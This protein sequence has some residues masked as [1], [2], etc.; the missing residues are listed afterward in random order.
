MFNPSASLIT[1]QNSVVMSEARQAHI[2]Q[3][4][5][6][7][8]AHNQI[9]SN[10]ILLPA[11]TGNS[12]SQYTN[13]GAVPN[14]PYLHGQTDVAMVNKTATEFGSHH[15]TVV[16]H[17]NIMATANME[18]V[19]QGDAM[20]DF[21]NI[22]PRL[23]HPFLDIDDL[24]DNNNLFLGDVDFSNTAMMH[25]HELGHPDVYTTPASANDSTTR[26]D[27]SDQHTPA[28]NDEN[29]QANVF[30][31]IGS[32]LPSLRNS[33]EPRDVSNRIRRPRAS[34][35]CWKVSQTDYVE[36]R[37]SVERSA[38]VLPADFTLPSRHTM[39]HFLERC[40][41][42]LYKHQPCLHVP[43]FCVGT[44]ALELILAMC[45]VGA[46][47]RFESHLGVIFFHA[48]K[49][50]IMSKWRDRHEEAVL[51]S[52]SQPS[53][54]SSDR[55]IETVNLQGHGVDGNPPLGTQRGPYVNDSHSLARQHRLQTM[56]ALLTLMSF[57]SWGPK[58]L[59]GEGIIL[60]SLLAVL[61]RE[62]GLAETEFSM[63]D[64]LP[65]QQRWQVWVNVE[66]MRRIKTIMYYFTNLQ[67]LAYNMTPPIPTAEVQCYTPATALE[68]LAGDAQQWEEARSR[69][70][71]SSVPFQAAFQSL[72]RRETGPG[73]DVDD[74][75]AISALG[76]YALIFGIL[77]CLY[78]LR[79]RHPVPFS[80]DWNADH[81]STL[82]SEDTSSII[83]ALQKWQSF[84]ER[85]PESTIEVE[86]S[87]GPISFN[88]IAC[89]RMA[90]FRLYA[91]LGPSRSLAT[92]DPEIIVR[93]FTSGA[94][95]RRHSQLIPMLLQAVHH[96]SVPVR[97]GIKY[98]ARSQTLFWSVNQSL[99][100]LECA[101]V[102]SKWLE[103]LASTIAQAPMTK[104]EKNLVLMLRAVVLESGFFTASELTIHKSRSSLLPEPEIGNDGTHTANKPRSLDSDVVV[105]KEGVINSYGYAFNA[106]LNGNQVTQQA[107]SPYSV[108]MGDE[109]S[110]L[111]RQISALNAAV[112]RL[113][114]EIFSS[115][116]VF[117]LVNTIGKTL[118]IH[119]SMLNSGLQ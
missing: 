83:H 28:V 79:Q 40:I 51:E 62:E 108:P 54:L 110:E 93:V 100:T 23:N 99:C 10:Q 53:P 1:P 88:S 69:S 44:A 103:S 63:H 33:L 82:S 65:L 41:N 80:R 68:W 73:G 67:S 107:Q 29:H 52:L 25:N 20:F 85:C 6:E 118:E 105:L 39:S 60:Q 81:G 32:P 64:D 11:M 38:K 47:L 5:M 50:L 3:A 43:T 75:P 15:D 89:L 17:G 46:Q 119:A 116:H 101:V 8:V 42:S 90:W 57:G 34:G 45:A 19:P 109:A 24:F 18:T 95:L 102:I 22:L 37:A 71:A 86:A 84:W 16:N 55:N 27:Y 96:L 72:F 35:P 58:I 117:D 98:V 113:W 61:A 115:T 48:S 74:V 7:N 94:P 56:Q 59:F 14:Q 4:V 114:A 104:Q 30:S 36:L 12:D 112:A 78:F 106:G 111:P 70:G 66:S 76:N 91:D 9:Q 13:H 26:T 49:A 92:R 31:R 21:G 97:L 2:P 77:Q 87:A